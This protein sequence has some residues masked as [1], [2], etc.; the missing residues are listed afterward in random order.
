MM[1]LPMLIVGRCAAIGS[2]RTGNWI[3]AHDY[4]AV[5]VETAGG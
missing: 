4:T 2:A 1:L 3:S 5:V